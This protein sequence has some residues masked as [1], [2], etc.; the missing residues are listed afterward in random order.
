MGNAAAKELA[1]IVLG[2][3]PL[4]HDISLFV[5][6]RMITPANSDTALRGKGSTW[7]AKG[8]KRPLIQ[9][10]VRGVRDTCS[11]IRDGRGHIIAIIYVCMEL[12][13]EV[14][15]L[16]RVTPAYPNQE[17]VEKDL[18]KRLKVPTGVDMYR[19]A[20][21]RNSV[22]SGG[23]TKSTYSVY[24]DKDVPRPLYVGRKLSSRHFYAVIRT[25]EDRVPVAKASMRGMSF[26]VSCQV[27][28]GVDLVAVTA[29]GQA[30]C[31]GGNAT[32]LVGARVI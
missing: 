9:Y 24:V 5:D 6:P 3:G 21:I 4:L 12:K 20:E 30:L 19:F 28:A 15:Y 29:I 16:L 26:N 25:A 7:T 8:A 27:S 13:K 22:L 31:P 10:Q 2:G 17:P 18:L 23:A 1:E 14:T 11:H 32:A